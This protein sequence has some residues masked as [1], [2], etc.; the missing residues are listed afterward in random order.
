LLLITIPLFYMNERNQRRVIKTVVEAS[1]DLN[2]SQANLLHVSGKMGD[3]LCIDPLF[4]LQL[5]GVICLRREVQM[6]QWVQVDGVNVKTWTS[7][8]CPV[9]MGE[10]SNCNNPEKPSELFCSGEI[11]N[12]GI[13]LECMNENY[14]LDEGVIN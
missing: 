1:Q 7:E 5:G 4:D 2:G 6:Y 3:K 8:V 9:F 11:I 12:K 10:S 13:E 14:I